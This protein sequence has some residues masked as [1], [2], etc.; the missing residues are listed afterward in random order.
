MYH[1]VKDAVRFNTG[2]TTMVLN[3]A[4]DG[5]AIG[6]NSYT[7]WTP[8]ANKKLRIMKIMVNNLT[9]ANADLLVGY[10][11][12][13]GAGA[14]FRQVIPTILTL[15]GIDVEISEADIPICG[16][17]PD[18]FCADTT[19]VTGSLGAIV[20]ECPTGAAGTGMQIAMELIEF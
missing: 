17:V 15:N 16:N 5:V 6:A 18:G 13:T 1:P 2:M 20:C 19:L 7:L 4:G 3:G 12:L 11:D 10:A 14:V 8:G 9:L